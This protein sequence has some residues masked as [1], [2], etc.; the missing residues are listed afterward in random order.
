VRQSRLQFMTPDALRGRV[1][2]VNQIF[3]GSSNEIGALRTGL[4][5]AL[6]GPVAAVGRVASARSR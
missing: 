2:A 3:V 4:T 6:I 1:T 5:T